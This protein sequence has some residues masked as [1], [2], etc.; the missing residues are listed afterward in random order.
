MTKQTDTYTPTTTPAKALAAYLAVHASDAD[1]A[2]HRGL[3]FID[4]NGKVR[5]KPDHF[6]AWY[7]ANEA[8]LWTGEVPTSRECRAVLK[9]AGLV[10]QVYL[11]PTHAAHKKLTGKRYGLYQGKAPAGTAKLPRRIVERKSPTPRKSAKVDDVTVANEGNATADA[12]QGPV[13]VLAGQV[14]EGELVAKQKQG[15][16]HKVVEIRKGASAVRLVTEDGGNLR[17]R[18]AT[19]VWV[20]Q[21]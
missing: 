11:L 20:Q 7:S 2:P 1:D 15:P 6:A 8:K 4:A 13:K 3:P 18:K 16:F 12:Q 19:P 21:A 17:P 10:Q 14:R 5:V 9:D